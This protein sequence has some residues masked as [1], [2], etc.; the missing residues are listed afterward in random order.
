MSDV[1]I[2]MRA[3]SQTHNPP[4]NSSRC[5]TRHS[6]SAAGIKDLHLRPSIGVR[7]RE[8]RDPQNLSMTHLFVTHVFENGPAH[9]A[10]MEVGL[11]RSALNDAL[12]S[13]IRRHFLIAL[14]MSGF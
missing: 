12:V 9:L 7:L 13:R 14:P 3:Y 5:A 4:L 10:G 2:C 11:R 1:L 8:Q 6:R